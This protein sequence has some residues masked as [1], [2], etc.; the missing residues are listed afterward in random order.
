MVGENER[1]DAIA[2]KARQFFT[3]FTDSNSQCT[4]VLDD[5]D[6]I[7]NLAESNPPLFTVEG[8]LGNLLNPRLKGDNLGVIVANQKIG[9]T[10]MLLSLAVTAGLSNPHFD[11]QCWG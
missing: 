9:K 2:I 1:A 6:S 11:Y 4:R 8:E 5:V 7:L 10:A 3:S